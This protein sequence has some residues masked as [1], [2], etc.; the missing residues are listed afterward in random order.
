MGFLKSKTLLSVWLYKKKYLITKFNNLPVD[1]KKK[2]K[3][4]HKNA[5]TNNR[6]VTHNNIA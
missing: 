3:S 6:E 1:D 5:S 2:K 4:S